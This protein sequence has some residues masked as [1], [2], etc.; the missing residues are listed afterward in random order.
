MFP[1]EFPAHL[2]ALQLKDTIAKYA[3]KL[4]DHLFSF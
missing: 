1:V 3:E 2:P 4:K